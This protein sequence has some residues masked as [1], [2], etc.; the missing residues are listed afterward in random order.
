MTENATLE[1][2][3][4]SQMLKITAENQSTFLIQIAD[5]ITKLEETIVQLQTRVSELEAASGINT[6]AQ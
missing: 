5:H 1:P 3:S 4:I 6:K 2:N